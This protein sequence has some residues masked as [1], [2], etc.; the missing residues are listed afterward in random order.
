MS[1]D[2]SGDQHRPSPL[3]RLLHLLRRGGQEEA[4]EEEILAMVD[5]GGES[6]AIEKTEKEMI[7][8]VFAF[9]NHTAEDVMT[10][11]T[12][13]TSIWVDD[14][15]EEIVRIIRE[16]GLS[17][18]PV[19]DKDMDDI[20]G[21]LSTRAFLLNMVS[22][23]PKP[24]RSIL[25]EAYFVPETVQADALFRDM[26]KK[27]IHL[28]IVADEYGGMSGI[29]TMEDL[30]E[31]IV[32]NIYD[33]TDPLERAEIVPLGTGQWRVQGTVSLEDLSEAM[34]IEIPASEDYD[35]LA[36]LVYSQFTV[37]PRDGETPAVDAAG[38]HIQVER[39]EDHRIE[40]AVVSLPE[41]EETA[42][43]E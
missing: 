34:G 2:P 22:G 14:E 29:V 18:F 31:E 5:A 8:N 42:E 6:G 4:T 38:L 28:A 40:S 16:T 19:Y 35:T 17:R 25:R 27:K 3:H 10:H 43:A 7:E 36:G 21:V 32:G 23:E 9:N 33:E 13:V 41:P 15:P 24:I 12:D 37:I 11:R 39:I 20:I 26:Q 1:P 30:L